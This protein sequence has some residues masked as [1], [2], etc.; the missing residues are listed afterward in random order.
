MAE[1]EPGTVFAGHR[2]D[3]VAGR[4]GMGVVYRATHLA[5][6]HVV[7]LKVIAPELAHDQRFRERFKRESRMAVSIRHP[8]VVPIHHAGEEDGVLFV[9]MD[10]IAG[11][12]LRALINST[13]GLAPD[14]VVKVIAPIASALDAAHERG[15]V[16]R[17]IKPANVLIERRAGDD[18]VYLTDFGLTKR[19]TG[20]TEMTA[21]GSFIGTIE[22]MAPEQIRG[23]ELDGRTDVYALGGVAFAAL[24]GRAPF[25]H[26]TED[27]AKMYAHLNEPPPRA[28]ETKAGVPTAF[29]PVIERAMAKNPADRY[30][31]AG[32][33][34]EALAAA[35]EG[36]PAD[37]AVGAATA[38][39]SMPFGPTVEAGV[40]DFPTTADPTAALPPEPAP[41]PSRRRALGALAGLAI[42]GVI[43]AGYVVLGGDDDGSGVG[44]APADGS[45]PPGTIGESIKTGPFPVGVSASGRTLFVADR[46]AGTVSSVNTLSGRVQESD[47]LGGA[48]ETAV[49]AGEFVW[50]VDGTNDLV[51][52]LD[53]NTLQSEVE[54]IEV[55]DMPRDSL[56]VDGTLWIT[57]RGTEDVPGETISRIDIGTIDRVSEVATNPFP[58]GLA[59]G[60]GVVWVSSREAGTVQGFTPTGGVAID[61]IDVGGEPHGLAVFDGYV[62]VA[63]GV[64]NKLQQVDPET[65][66]VQ[67]IPLGEGSE[68]RDVVAAFGSIWVSA[69]DGKVRQVDPDSLE[70]IKT[71]DVRTP[72]EGIT[73][74]DDA[75]WVAGGQGGDLVEIDP[76]P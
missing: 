26:V 14:Q 42:A 65:G 51:I 4:G 60:D 48:I 22:Y 12:D 69:G 45:L 40:A 19:A 68:P 59:D 27:I 56:V 34:G 5:L 18:R 23:G 64:S 44:G 70:V 63:N 33:L 32:Q 29:D 58:R 52:P 66:D 21:S 24:T 53:P 36:R 17:D 37:P 49:A 13:G 41:P 7:A 57:N 71:L 20:A 28:S 67:G 50:A 54:T 2:I 61:P 31:S 8:N 73:A 43:A 47:P 35:A 25:A 10:F 6:D 74:N 15:L 38:V 1:L 76:S 9:T 39:A 72:L 55:G 75:V 62:W 16:H 46:E 11:S 30:Q 3:E